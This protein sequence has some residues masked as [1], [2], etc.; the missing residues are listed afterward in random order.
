MR[1]KIILIYSAIIA[2]LGYYAFLCQQRFANDLEAYRKS[3]LLANNA[4]KVIQTAARNNLWKIEK[5]HQ[6]NPLAPNKAL[7]DTGQIIYA[8]LDSLKLPPFDTL[9]GDITAH[10]TTQLQQLETAIALHDSLFNLS[11]QTVKPY[12]PGPIRHIPLLDISQ[13]EKGNEE[14]LTGMVFSTQYC[15]TSTDLQFWVNDKPVQVIDG[16]GQLK[17][18]FH[19]PGT[20]HLK[21]LAK[22]A[23]SAGYYENVQHTIPMYI[24]P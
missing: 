15:A 14:F 2:M 7:R 12:L 18:V 20:H 3:S 8:R 21:I 10:L 19:R 9:S 13:D 24:R 5:D 6:N 22:L 4:F 17:T 23:A 11:E 16:V 1:I